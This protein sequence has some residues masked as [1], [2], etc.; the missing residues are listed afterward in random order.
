[1]MTHVWRTNRRLFLLFGLLV[2]GLWM[3]FGSTRASQAGSAV[4]SAQPASTPNPAW[5]CTVV[6][7]NGL[8]LRAGPGTNYAVVTLLR[9]TRTQPVKVRPLAASRD[10]TWMQVVKIGGSKPPTGWVLAGPTNIVCTVP[11]AQLPQGVV[12]PT[13]APPS[14]SPTP[15]SISYS[16][17]PNQGGN[18]DGLDGT[19][20]VDRAALARGANEPVFRD[21]LSIQMDV[22]DPDAARGT[23]IKSVEFTIRN[24]DTGDEYYFHRETNAPY[25]L[26]GNQGSTCD[27]AWRFQQ[28]G[29]VWPKSDRPVAEGWDGRIDPNTVYRADIRAVSEDGSKQGNW[30]FT[31]RMIPANTPNHAVTMVPS[32]SFSRSNTDYDAEVRVQYD[33]VVDNAGGTVTFGDHMV[34]QLA[35]TD[36]FGNPRSDG[37]GEVQFEVRDSDSGEVVYQH[38]ERSAP[39]CVF[40]NSQSFC[41]T[42]W[43]FADTDYQWPPSDDPSIGDHQ[44]LLGSTYQVFMVVRDTDG[45]DIGSWDFA[46]DVQS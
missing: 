22:R 43:R 3:G 13:P 26:F 38:T 25:C 5:E 37:V 46:F 2:G 4:S 6:A 24:D 18:P 20:L 16:P 23:G 29:Q 19:I 9:G 45:N 10:R 41:N 27:T 42:V 17:A 34:F 1:M 36:A 7:A 33:A 11:I 40:G 35:V 44:M 14:A 15:D 31:F 21:L 28:T 32:T 8:N 12:P 39:Y 30:N